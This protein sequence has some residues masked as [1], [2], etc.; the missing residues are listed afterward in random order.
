MYV[1]VSL[2]FHKRQLF[3]GNTCRGK[4]IRKPCHVEKGFNVFLS[5]KTWDGTEYLSIGIFEN[6]PNTAACKEPSQPGHADFSQYLI[7][8]FNFLQ[9][10]RTISFLCII[11]R[12]QSLSFHTW[13]LKSI[14]DHD[15]YKPFN[16]K[17]EKKEKKVVS[18][19]I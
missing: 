3:G 19:Y 2:C 4:L 13:V 8:Q 5:T 6:R 18:T 12:S 16:R 9:K 17:M 7:L 10:P 11:F 14:V 15:G 1:P